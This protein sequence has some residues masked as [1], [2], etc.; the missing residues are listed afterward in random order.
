RAL[1]PPPPLCLPAAPPGRPA[2]AALA[3]H[4]RDLPAFLRRRAGRPV[5]R[6]LRPRGAARGVQPY[7]ELRREG[8]RR[9][10]AASPAARA[11]GVTVKRALAIVALVL[12]LGLAASADAQRR[13]FSHHGSFGGHG[14]VGHRPF[15]HSRSHVFIDGGFFFDPFFPYFYSYPYPY[16]YYAPYPYPYPPPGDGG[17]GEPPPEAESEPRAENA[18]PSREEAEPASYGLVQLRGVPDGAAVDLD[19]RF[20]LTA[21]RLDERW[22]AVPYGKHTRVDHERVLA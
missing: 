5:R 7:R 14:F 13:G 22:L 8:R 20:W 4:A 11:R 2:P 9:G 21:E 10:A 6:L 1:P 12:A 16:P 3:G 19:G 15:F 18:P 17:W